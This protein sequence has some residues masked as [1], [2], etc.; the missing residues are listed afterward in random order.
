MAQ[1]FLEWAASNEPT[2]QRLR[3]IATIWLVPIMDVDRVSIGAGGKDS[4]PRDHNRDWD[5]NPFYPAVAAAQAR[6]ASLHE[7]EKLDVFLDIHN[8]GD[9]KLLH[10]FYGPNHWEK[11]P[12][13]SQRNHARWLELAKRTIVEPLPLKPEYETI[14]Y[15]ATEEELNRVSA[16]W[17]RNHADPHVL[18]TTFEA[19][20]NTPHSTQEGYQTAGSQLA[21][22]LTQYLLEDPRRN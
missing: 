10:Y 7:A 4:I 15:I 11:L 6:L 5:D 12:P 1:G 22:T 21:E 13:V 14:T 19:A 3:S 20:C 16:N 18:A 2:A 9:D 8:P 17:V